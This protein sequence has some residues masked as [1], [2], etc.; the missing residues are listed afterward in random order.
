MTS[1]VSRIGNTANCPVT[2]RYAPTGAIPSAMP[3]TMWHQAV[4]RLVRLYPNSTV[5]ARG[6]RQNA[7][8]LIHAAVA[9]NSRALTIINHKAFRAEMRPAGMSR[10]AVR[11]FIASMLRSA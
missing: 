7:R 2:A 1:P 8:K 10:W 4:K 6:E 5:S 9:A 3:S 11:G